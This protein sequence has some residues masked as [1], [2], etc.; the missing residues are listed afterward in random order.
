MEYLEQGDLWSRI[1]SGTLTDIKEIHCYFK[2]ILIGVGYLHSVGVSH[3]DLKPENILING[4]RL[5]IVFYELVYII[6]IV[7]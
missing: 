1:N 6:L 2:Q 7:L 5:K 3:R 4:Q